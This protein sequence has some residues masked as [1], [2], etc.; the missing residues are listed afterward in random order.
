MILETSDK[1]TRDRWIETLVLHH[2]GGGLCDWVGDEYGEFR[3]GTDAE[4]RLLHK[5]TQIELWTWTWQRARKT[6]SG[7]SNIY[8]REKHAT[9]YTLETIERG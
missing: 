2:C 9:K 6:A 1:Y 7:A 3:M 4:T 5:Y 8:P